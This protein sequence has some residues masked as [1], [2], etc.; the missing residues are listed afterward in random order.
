MLLSRGECFN[1]DDYRAYMDKNIELLSMNK[2]NL[3]GFTFA[4]K[5]VYAIKGYSSSAG[6]PDWLASHEPATQT[7]NSILALLKNGATLKGTTIT[8]ELMYSLNGENYHYGTPINPKD[9]NRIPGGSSSGSAVTVAAGLTDFSLGTDTGGSIRIPSSYCGIYGIRPTHGVID[10]KGVIPLAKSFDTVGWMANTPEILLSVGETLLPANNNK[11]EFSKFIVAKDAWELSN[12]EIVTAFQPI[13]EAIKK[14]ASQY[15]TINLAEEGLKEW[16]ETFRILQGL[17]IWE[18]H[19]DWITQEKPKFG[20]GIA[21]R[22]QMASL[23]DSNEKEKY[24][25]KRSIIRDKMEMLLKEDGVLIIP[26][27]PGKAPLVNLPVADLEVY[28]SNTLQLCCIAGLSGFPQ[29]NIPFCGV[30]GTPIGL[31]FIAGKNQD[32]KL[33][34]YVQKWSKSNSINGTN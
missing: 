28:R 25:K 21:E 27:A 6:N 30:N 33:L 22:F 18:E 2:G 23:I 3:D 31:S 29:V 15:E 8:D 26:T 14:S 34:Q 16:A 9:K 10:I 13:L 32:L 1:V 4:V 11:D 5:D 17:E 7:A 12:E 20:P 24:R 19:K